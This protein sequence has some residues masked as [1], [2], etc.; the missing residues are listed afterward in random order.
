[1]SSEHDPRR[2]EVAAYLLGALEP[3]EA[4]ALERH[5]EGCPDCR[6]ELRWLEPALQTLPESVEPVDP[7]PA[8][9]DRV[10]SQ[11][12]AEAGSTQSDAAVGRRPSWLRGRRPLAAVAALALVAA[13][14]V[15]SAVRGDRSGGEAEGTTVAAAGRAPG[16]TVKMIARGDGR[17]ATLELSGVHEM[18]SDRVLEAWVQRDGIVSPVRRALFVPDRD[19]RAST[20]IPSTEGVEAVMVTAEPRGGSEQPT[21]TPMVTLQMPG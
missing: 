16:V 5:L 12:R 8:L 11:A 4:G 7:P 1:M 15:G 13:L 19:G 18:S 10:L 20:R 17:E 6:A 2:E 14:I 9:R 21:S 3:A